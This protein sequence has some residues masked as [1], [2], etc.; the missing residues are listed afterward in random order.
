MRRAALIFNPFSGRYSPRRAARLRQA[1]ETLRASGVAVEMFEAA[2]S[3][4]GREHARQASS[5]GCDAVIACGGDGTVHEVLQ[6][7]AGTATALGVIPLGTANALA[8]NLGLSGSPVAVVHKLLQAEPAAVPVGRIHYTALDGNP[9]SCYF[10]VAAGIGPDALLMSRLD[11]RRKQRYGYA[12]YLAEATRIWA[13]HKFPLFE[14]EVTPEDNSDNSITASERRLFRASQLLAVRVRSF[15]GALGE[16]A[17]GATLRNPFLHL[18]AFETR[19]RLAY[20]KF[21]I[22]VLAGRHHFSGAVTLHEISQL[23]CRSVAGSRETIFVEAD[24]ELLGALPARM[25]MAA[26]TVNLLIPSGARP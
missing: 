8:A 15:G 2:S 13:T 19:S 22:A 5:Q 12:L 17:P 26:E 23:D 4:V 16:L 14:V 24:G 10:L 21:L 7:L 20:F 11:P 3:R 6:G 18:I 25:E 9:A 1:A